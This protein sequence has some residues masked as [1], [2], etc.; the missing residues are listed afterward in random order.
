[1][2]TGLPFSQCRSRNG[3]IKDVTR[4]RDK[5]IG[6]QGGSPGALWFHWDELTGRS[7]LAPVSLSRGPFL[8][9]F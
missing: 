6:A 2:D 7:F 1:M 3:E 5:Q 8:L 4:A 9:P